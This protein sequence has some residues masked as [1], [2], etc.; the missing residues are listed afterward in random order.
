MNIRL[1]KRLKRMF[2]ENKAGEEI[3]IGLLSLKEP[4]MPCVIEGAMTRM[5]GR[6]RGGRPQWTMTLLLVEP[7]KK[8]NNLRL[9]WVIPFFNNTRP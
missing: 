4:G 7:L 3:M 8:T 9:G 2:R 1:H 6:M 5:R